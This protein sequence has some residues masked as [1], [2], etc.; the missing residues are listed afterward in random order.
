VY[1][2][3]LLVI[4]ITSM[5]DVSDLLEARQLP[6]ISR[7][8]HVRLE[9]VL[10]SVTSRRVRRC[11]HN[12]VT[13]LRLDILSPRFLQITIAHS[14]I[15]EPAETSERAY[16]DMLVKARKPSFVAKN[17]KD[18]EMIPCVIADGMRDIALLC[19]ETDRA[20]R[21][22]LLHISWGISEDQ[23]RAGDYS[24]VCTYLCAIYL[25]QLWRPLYTG[26]SYGYDS[27]IPYLIISEETC[28]HM[29]CR[30]HH[31]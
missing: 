27:T 8:L 28:Q 30:A 20:V 5:E 3:K 4:T 29:G 7:F 2:T 1:R 25:H 24:C 21:K 12:A 16:L 22:E 18:K 31:C 10:F 11:L 15:N 19:R 17:V 6:E 9:L 14:H 13:L 23:K 26:C